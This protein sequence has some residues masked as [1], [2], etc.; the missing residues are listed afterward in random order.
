[1]ADGDGRPDTGRGAPDAGI[2]EGGPRW[3]GE[4]LAT[5]RQVRRS[6]TSIELA[7]EFVASWMRSHDL[8]AAELAHHVDRHVEAEVSALR[9]LRAYGARV[10]AE[11][12]DGPCP[13]PVMTWTPY[14]ASPW[15]A[16]NGITLG[17]IRDLEGLLGAGYRLGNGLRKAEE[18]RRQAAL[19]SSGRLQFV[20]ATRDGIPFWCAEVVPTEGGPALRFDVTRPRA[21]CPSLPECRE[22][23]DGLVAAV[24]AGNPRP[25]L[26]APG[27]GRA[28]GPL[29][30]AG[31]RR[32]A[33][34]GPALS[35]G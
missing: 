17:F 9:A 27:P 32:S 23:F 16:A 6:G 30:R 24:A 22:A 3:V 25:A 28:R 29:R 31:L 15:T 33:L 13:M 14:L 19:A 10:A 7:A 35:W 11:A 34:R 21:P 4:Y 12:G 20:A 18:A 1:M 2:G 26:A 8:D 5:L